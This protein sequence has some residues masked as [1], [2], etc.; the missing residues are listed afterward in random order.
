MDVLSW[1]RL[2]TG[3]TLSNGYT[4]LFLLMTL[5]SLGPC[6]WVPEKKLVLPLGTEL[7]AFLTSSPLFPIVHQ[8]NGNINYLRTEICF[9][10]L[11]VNFRALNKFWELSLSAHLCVLS[12]VWLFQPHGLQLSGLLHP[13][14]FPEGIL[15]RVA[16][17][18]SPKMIKE[19]D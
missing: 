14:N 3:T 9:S 10:F 11:L 15:E 16:L 19:N 12:R 1:S 6:L 8:S 5:N 4:W 7:Q 13:W 18:C 2:E 17:Y